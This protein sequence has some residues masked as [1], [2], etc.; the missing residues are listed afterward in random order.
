VRQPDA[1]ERAIQV[2]GA[3]DLQDRDQGHLDR[4]DEQPDDDDEQDPP[5]AE[6][7][8]RERV[9]RERGDRDRDDRRGNGHDQAVEE[10][11]AHAVAR[12]DGFVVRQRPL[13]GFERVE[14]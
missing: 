5:S 9:G 6:R 12:K 7:D 8:P 13:I 14:Q 11:V 2:A 4:D 10:R 3:V 1:E